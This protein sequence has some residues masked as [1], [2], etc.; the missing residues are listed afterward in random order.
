MY[1]RILR[2]FCLLPLVWCLGAG[3][4]LA[5]KVKIDAGA[6]PSLDGAPEEGVVMEPTHKE[7]WLIMPRMGYMKAFEAFGPNPL[8][9]QPAAGTDP[10]AVNNAT[11]MGAGRWEG[12]GQWMV[13]LEY[14]QDISTKFFFTVDVDG[15]LIGEPGWG[16]R[17]TPLS[18]APVSMGAGSRS[19]LTAAGM[20]TYIALGDSSTSWLRLAAKGGY[21]YGVSMPLWANVEFQQH[22]TL[23]DAS[24]YLNFSIQ[25]QLGVLPPAAAPPLTDDVLRG[26]WVDQM[27][28]FAGFQ[29]GLARVFNDRA[30]RKPDNPAEKLAP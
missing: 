11:P 26:L 15:V 9:V 21:L 10:A 18:D 6:A 12:V 19:L 13:G 28:L 16:V 22:I 24:S 3:S 23:A 7:K 29:V 8:T 1:G 2:L 30:T 20:G 14:R 4:A 17:L 27:R 25:G 5:Q